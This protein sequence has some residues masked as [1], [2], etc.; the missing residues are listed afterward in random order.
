LDETIKTA[1]TAALSQNTGE[2]RDGMN[3]LERLRRRAD[4]TA[5]QRTT[6]QLNVAA[7]LQF[8]GR[9]REALDIL[10][11]L[12]D[13]AA[14]DPRFDLWIALKTGV[15]SAALGRVED[16]SQCF[17]GALAAATDTN[18]LLLRASIALEAGKLRKRLGD[19][20]GAS[21]LWEAALRDYEAAGDE[22]H[23]ARTRSNLAA[24]ALEH[25]DPERQEA[26]IR[27]LKDLAQEK[28][29]TGDVSGYSTNCSCLSVYY[30]R[31]RRF[32]AA[33]GFAR[34][35]LSASRDVGDQIEIARSL[36]NLGRIYVD[37]RQ[38]TAARV[39]VIEAKKLGEALGDEQVVHRAEEALGVVSDM[40]RQAHLNGEQLGAKAACACGSG[41]AYHDCCGRA[42]FDPLPA[43]RPESLSNL[44]PHVEGSD[45]SGSHLDFVMRD[46]EEVSRRRGWQRVRVHEGW[47]EVSELADAANIHLS[48]ARAIAS[49]AQDEP[50]GIEKPAAAVVLSTCALEAFANQ[51]AFFVHEARQQGNADPAWISIATEDPL[52]FQRRTSLIE[53]WSVL[54]TALCG[55]YWPPEKTLWEDVR[56]LVDIRNELIHFKAAEYE[57]VIP[58]PREPHRMI[59]RMPPGVSPRPIAASW[60]NRLL[61]PALA[62]W[63]V[64]VADSLIRYFRTAYGKMRT[65]SR[66]E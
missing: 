55:T 48:A 4:L 51:V 58:P 24:L 36:L 9:H 56:R 6:I 15:S 11:R 62:D 50:D 61:T 25:P 39:A 60:A 46:G 64:S 29:A 5:V 12:R 33:L 28:L 22:Q 52:E 40:A 65:M 14:D 43:V 20:E 16:A 37:V 10:S 13:D 47:Y 30:H 17:E 66:V 2:Q 63:A 18:D 3:A 53:K 59:Q 35:E 32:D 42:D 54:G 49:E 27:L 57:Q 41:R 38:P 26:A 23:V 45:S 34:K 7:G 19:V 44:R 1:G 31:K 8:Q 21:R